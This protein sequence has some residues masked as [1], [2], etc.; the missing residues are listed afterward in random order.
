MGT[1]LLV[2][3]DENIS[4]LISLHLSNAGYQVSVEYD[5]SLGLQNALSNDYSLV[6]LDI[7]LPGKNG[8]EICAALRKKKKYI[9][10]MMITSRSEESDKI[11]GFE[12]GA[13]DY[14]VKP[15]SI[16]ELLARVNAII[17][18]SKANEI[19][20]LENNPKIVCY[21]LEID[22]QNRI[23]TIAGNRVELSPKEFDLLHILAKHPGRSYSRQQLLDNVWGYQFDGFEHTVNSHINRLRTKIEEDITKPKFILT[24]WGVGYRFN[25]E[26]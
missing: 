2:E 25:S 17:R 1:I 4:E 21:N 24:S 16:K 22:V 6:L 23:T 11:S 19:E 12:N 13:D 26:I 5:G 7:M 20:A 18:R 8:L 10:V 15:F 14:I 3:D 9:P